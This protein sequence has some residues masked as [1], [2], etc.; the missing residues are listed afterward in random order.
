M[1]L[2]LIS[3]SVSELFIEKEFMGILKEKNAFA[4]IIAQC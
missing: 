2:G 3:Q 4:A 1:S